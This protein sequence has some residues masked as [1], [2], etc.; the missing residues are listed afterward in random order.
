M[1]TALRFLTILP[2]PG[3]HRAPGHA[4]VISFPL[5]GALVGLAW[6]GA[7]SLGM[8]LDMPLAAAAFV[9]VVDAVLTGTLHLDACG[10][11]ADGVASRRGPED[12]IRIMREPAVGAAG[13]AAIVVVTVLRFALLAGAPAAGLALVAAPVAGRTAMILL[14][15]LLPARDRGSLAAAFAR[16]GPLATLTTVAV[17]LAAV[18]LAGGLQGAVA[19]AGSLAAVTVYGLLWR[20]RFGGLTGDGAGAGGLLAETTA[21]LVIVA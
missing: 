10:D 13:A 19:L 4:T 9:L 20:K 12:A 7:F 8:L 18:A 21:L 11:V 1:R 16:P 5:V 15:A 3:E 17:A 2:V 6:L 14:L